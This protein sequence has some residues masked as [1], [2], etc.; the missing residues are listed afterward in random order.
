[1]SENGRLHLGWFPRKNGII[2]FL[3]G[4]KSMYYFI[5]MIQMIVFVLKNE[6]I[7]RVF[8]NVKYY[9]PIRVTLAIT[10]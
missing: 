4:I 2:L 7:L 1:M 9:V 6:I 3:R 8:L 5:Q 10:E